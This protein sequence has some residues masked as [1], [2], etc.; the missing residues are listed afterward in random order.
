MHD[1]KASFA[2]EPKYLMDSENFYWNP[3]CPE[4]HLRFSL[5]CT[6]MQISEMR[7]PVR[8]FRGG[9]LV[10]PSAILPDHIES[11]TRRLV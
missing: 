1:D 3:L 6:L 4:N 7:I 8:I 9:H 11:N 5:E 10:E 2:T